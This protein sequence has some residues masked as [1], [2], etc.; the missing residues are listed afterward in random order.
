MNLA[1]DFSVYVALEGHKTK[2]ALITARYLD[3]LFVRRK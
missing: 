3:M 2:R 1:P